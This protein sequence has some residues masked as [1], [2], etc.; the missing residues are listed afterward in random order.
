MYRSERAYRPPPPPS[1]S[2]SKLYWIFRRTSY[3]SLP[4]PPPLFGRNCP[5]K[6]RQI[7]RRT[8]IHPFSP[9]LFPAPEKTRLLYVCRAY[10]SPPPVP[11]F[12]MPWEKSRYALL[13]AHFSISFSPSSPF[14]SSHP[15]E[16]HAFCIGYTEFIPLA[17]PPLFP[18]PLSYYPLIFFLNKHASCLAH[19]ALTRTWRSTS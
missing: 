2:C 6:M 12:P 9:S 3:P 17:L 11:L 5:N 7:L 8:L 10:P 1:S 18:S 19:R 15:L 13:I 16:K 14:P 4:V